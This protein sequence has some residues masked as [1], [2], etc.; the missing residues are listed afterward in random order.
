MMQ[1]GSSDV[2]IGS[3]ATCTVQSCRVLENVSRAQRVQ[4]CAY[5]HPRSDGIFPAVSCGSTILVINANWFIE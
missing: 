4:A 2:R 1:V 5:S 3:H